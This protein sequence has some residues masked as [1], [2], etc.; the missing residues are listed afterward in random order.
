MPTPTPESMQSELMPHQGTEPQ[1]AK[2][3]QILAY[4]EATI[5]LPAVTFSSFIPRASASIYTK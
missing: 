5:P 3:P 1:V 2:V 4:E